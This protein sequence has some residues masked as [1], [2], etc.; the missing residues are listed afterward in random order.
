MR[1]E[2]LKI[3]EAEQLN[4]LNQIVLLLKKQPGVR[5]VML[6]AAKQ[7]CSVLFD[8]QVISSGQLQTLLQDA[9]IQTIV[10]KAATTPC[11]GSCGG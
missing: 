10:A 8:E 9:G 4:D 5:D 2:T 1:T 6:I 7:E 11:C 3:V